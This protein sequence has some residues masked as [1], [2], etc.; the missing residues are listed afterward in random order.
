M[1]PLFLT[2]VISAFSCL[3]NVIAAPT[4]PKEFLIEDFEDERARI[5]ALREYEKQMKYF[6]EPGSHDPG[7]N[8]LMGHYDTRYFKGLL[9]YAEKRDTQVHM[10]RAYLDTFR[11]NGI[12]TWIAH[13]TLLGWWWNAKVWLDDLPKKPR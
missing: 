9:T 4:P 5:H 7:D 8:E 1:K 3:Y 6:H 10:I 11:E 13:G 2:I 12:E